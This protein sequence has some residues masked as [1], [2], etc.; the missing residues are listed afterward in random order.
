MDRHMSTL[1]RPLNQRGAVKGRQEAHH[2]ASKLAVMQRCRS[3]CEGCGE[4][5]VL[6]WAHAFGR[7]HIVSEPWCSSPELTLG[8]CR[9][10]HRDVDEGIDPNK[11][12]R[13]RWICVT[14]FA[15]KHGLPIPSTADHDELGAIRALVDAVELQP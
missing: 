4:G 1:P 10:C 2:R 12:Q 5:R 7:R 3:V 8:L 11:Q 15:A 9:Q 13:L 14:R 6:D